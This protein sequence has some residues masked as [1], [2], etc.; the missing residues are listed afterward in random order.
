MSQTIKRGAKGVRRAAAARTN[1][2]RV[3]KARQSTGS[4]LDRLVGLIPISEQRLHQV[5]LALIFAGAAALAWVVA[6]FAG[7]PTIAAAELASF[8]SSAG[9]EVRRVEV[10]GVERMNEVSVY[11]K[12]LAERDRAM[13]LVDLVALRAEL[14]R[15]PWVEDARVSRQLPDTLI[16]D[17][18]ERSPHAALRKGSGMVLIDAEGNELE[19]VSAERAARMLVLAGPGA[20][21][22]VPELERLLKTAPGL[23]GKVR[24]AEWVGN[25]R[26]NLTF[27]TGQ[28]LAL[29]EGDDQSASAL[30]AFAKLDGANRLLGGQVAT[31]DM[32]ALDR[33]YLRV[34]GRSEQA[35]KDA[36]ELAAAK[37]KA[38]AAATAQEH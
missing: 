15:F 25:R 5:C 22:R 11:E 12:V 2:A 14:L 17:I 18:V 27:R 7:V 31:F 30:I 8:A 10:R 37:A 16:V 24:E 35:A 19:A 34:P 36:A 38:K 29:P 33:I 3:A 13:P 21:R 1:K 32:R 6:S 20:A 23:R 28:V 4:A 26:W 9:F